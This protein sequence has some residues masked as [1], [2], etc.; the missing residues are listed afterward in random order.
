[1]FTLSGL[2]LN[3]TSS[4]TKVF[5]ECG[6]PFSFEC[7]LLSGVPIIGQALKNCAK[8]SMNAIVIS[9]LS[10]APSTVSPDCGRSCPQSVLILRICSVALGTGTE[11]K[12][13]QKWWQYLL[14]KVWS[15]KKPFVSSLF[16]SRQNS[17]AE[18][19][20]AAA[21]HYLL[22]ILVKGIPQTMLHSL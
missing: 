11:G 19:K 16:L 2:K 17:M 22:P 7:I 14:R 8:G 9:L 10:A 20:S 5:S 3:R 13:P 12:Q 4:T 18:K 6:A 15:R 1:M 21:S